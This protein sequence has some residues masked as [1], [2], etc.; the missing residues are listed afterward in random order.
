MKLAIA[1]SVE[2]SSYGHFAQAMRSISEPIELI[3]TGQQPGV[4]FLAYQYARKKGIPYQILVVKEY[5][6]R[7]NKAWLLARNAYLVKS[8]DC[9][10][11]IATDASNTGKML[12]KLT[13]QIKRPL[14]F[15]EPPA[16]GA[17]QSVAARY[18]EEI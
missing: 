17:L 15:F 11:A 12:H 14:L 8:A 10:L 16:P 18:G 4:E 13:A 2:Y 1:G 3:I 9:V 7:A 5:T 6:R